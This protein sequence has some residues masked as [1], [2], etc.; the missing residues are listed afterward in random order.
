MAMGF[1][2]KNGTHGVMANSG[3][4]NII[5]SNCGL[6]ATEFTRDAIFQNGKIKRTAIKMADKVISS[7]EITREKITSLASN[8]IILRMN[9]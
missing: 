3:F 4:G 8:G 1:W 5:T 6:I 7:G 2:K 9:F